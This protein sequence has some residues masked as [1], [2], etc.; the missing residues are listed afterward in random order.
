VRTEKR[1][2]CVTLEFLAL[3]F[4][5]ESAELL[6]THALVLQEFSEAFY[7]KHFHLAESEGLQGAGMVEE[8]HDVMSDLHLLIAQPNVYFPEAE[9]LGGLGV[10]CHFAQTFMDQIKPYAE[11]WLRAPPG[12]RS[13]SGAKI[14][15]SDNRLHWPLLT[16]SMERT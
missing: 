7:E 9:K 15:G 12:Y 13:P 11:K 1:N 5:S 16:N 2:L 3:C 8:V 10:A 4:N 6:R 14:N